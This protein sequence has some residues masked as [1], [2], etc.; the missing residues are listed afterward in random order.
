MK[1][2][3]KRLLVLSFI[4]LVTVVFL[5]VAL[6]LISQRLPVRIKEAKADATYQASTVASL[7]GAMLDTA[8][9]SVISVAGISAM[10]DTA[11]RDRLL[12]EALT[13]NPTLSRLYLIDS[14][15]KIYA[16]YDHSALQDSQLLGFDMSSNKLVKQVF[17][18]EQTLWSDNFF[19]P[20]NGSSTVALGVKADYGV[21]IAEMRFD[22]LQGMANEWI[23]H[24]NTPVLVID[25][26]GDWVSDNVQH[27][28]QFHNW[29]Q[30]AIGQGLESDDTAVY[31]LL[32]QQVY[33]ATADVPYLGWRVI[34]GVPAKMENPAIRELVIG[35][36]FS[37]LLAMVMAILLAPWC[38]MLIQRPVLALVEQAKR[39]AAGG[40]P[41]ALEGVIKEFNTLG[42]DICAMA[43][44][45]IEKEQQALE[46]EQHVKALL[47]NS[48][49]VAILQLSKAGK[50]QDCN[51]VASETLNIS[52]ESIKE[53]YLSD[54]LVVD[55]ERID[56]N[57]LFEQVL[58]QGQA[59][60]DISIDS[61]E[62]P[63]K[64]FL[65]SLFAIRG[66]KEQLVCMLVDVTRQ[67]SMAEALVKA[68]RRSNEILEIAPA[69]M[70]V[71]TYA[72][73]LGFLIIDANQM[74]CEQ[75]GIERDDFVG[76]VDRG[77]DRWL[78]QD[79]RSRMVTQF[80]EDKAVSQFFVWMRDKA[81][82]PF[83]CE[84]SATMM[85]VD[86]EAFSIFV[87]RNVTTEYEMRY[88]LAMLNDEL[89]MTVQLRTEALQDAN[90][91]LSTTLNE[92]KSTQNELIQSE[93]LSALG[94]MVA[95]ISHE[96]NTPLGNGLMAASTLQNMQ[97]EFQ[98]A[99][100]EGLRKSVLD[101][102][103]VDLETS[104]EIILRNLERASYLVA[105]FKQVAVDRTSSQRR[106]FSLLD[107]VEEVLVTL[108]PS[109]KYRPITF[110]VEIADDVFLDSYPGEFGQVL[111][112][113]V[114]N[115]LVHAFEEEQEG[116]ITV[117]ADIIDRFHVQLLV[118][119]N[120][121]GMS[122]EIQAKIFD[123]FFTT[124]MGSGGS[125]LGMHIIHNLVTGVIGGSIEVTSES[126][127]GTTF[128]LM[129]PT[130]AP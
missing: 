121:L 66:E 33:A 62:G 77:G 108:K 119:D 2:T 18:D 7:L 55:S 120:G 72:G 122:E 26:I 6:V 96:L 109:Y 84:I 127:Q 88:Q 97:E 58:S 81:R 56:F 123:P 21:L 94:G 75:F 22:Q 125:G 69:A 51:P 3:I 47:D 17:D 27:T 85:E 8:E 76:S 31:D 104:S 28:S 15:R 126:G 59:V 103:L 42:E 67:V 74:L 110:K 98:T 14:S 71:A 86:N 100:K 130:N 106:Y 54:L 48:P 65:G 52:A 128:A 29:S 92:L 116:V 102:F 79:D 93:K 124:K 9:Q 111:T 115:A 43:Q 99:L 80:I 10:G 5:L 107:V 39:I 36:V 114:Q 70:M 25:A 4:G 46:S 34:V 30:S 73:E 37:L 35:I 112:N 101:R 50:I 129:L 87:Y 95:G 91:E 61:R 12:Q 41:V 113:L 44:R 13:H 63:P 83:L 19:S 53:S 38:A 64:H 82:N 60:N 118:S 16:I 49:M 45:I 23:N 90:A 32:G 1:V 24:I 20:F 89:E 117:H 68:Q 40:S 57:L 78:S 105:S 11:L